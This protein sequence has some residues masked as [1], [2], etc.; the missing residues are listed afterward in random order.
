MSAIILGWNPEKSGF[1]IDYADVITHVDR[2]GSYP[3][4]W[5]VANRVKIPVN[6][7]A[8]LLLQGGQGRGLLGHATVRSAPY[9]DQHYADHTVTV[10]YVEVEFD[11]LLPKNA[12]IEPSLLEQKVPGVGW[13]QVYSSGYRVPASEEL[14]LRELWA[15]HSTARTGDPTEPTPGTYPEGALL[16]TLANRYERD[17]RARKACLD[18]HGYDCLACG[19]SF[20]RVYGAIGAEFVH[21]HHVVPI[22]KLGERYQVDPVKDL[23]PLCANCHAMAHRRAPQ[24]Y[25]VKELQRHISRRQRKTSR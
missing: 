15:Q 20:E 4:R 16:R 9:P 22:S 17:P 21:V 10:N 25:S 3:T 18:H 8:W 19:F 6:S 24:P 11:S 7:D 5:S 1:G 13:R 23:V 14:P 2:T 12:A